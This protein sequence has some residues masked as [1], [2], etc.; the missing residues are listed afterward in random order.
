MVTLPSV[1]INGTPKQSLFDDN[2]TAL[3]AIDAAMLAVQK[4]APH[5]R[6]YYVQ[7][8]EAY[9]TALAEHTARISKLNT[10]RRELLQIVEHLL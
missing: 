8:G 6:D 5:G 1:H 4:A 2:M 10:V 7:D 9:K 3:E